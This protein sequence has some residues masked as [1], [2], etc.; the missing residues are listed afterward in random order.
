MPI[1][2]SIIA[3]VL[4]MVLY[5]IFIWK[6]DKYEPEPIRFIV[7]HF[8]WGAFGAVLFGV[9]GSM[10]LSLLTGF[11]G[12]GEVENAVRTILFAPISEETAK[13]V[14]L[15]W[16]INSRKFDNITDGIV[17]GTAIGLGFG[18]TENFMYFVSYGT[19]VSSWVNIVIIRSLFSAVMHG[20][21]TGTLGGFL[22]LAKYSTDFGRA[23]YPVAGI[24]CAVFIHFVW[25]ATVSFQITL[26]FGFLF[27]IALIVV[28]IS[29]IRF[30]VKNEKRIIEL[31]LE[32]E[33]LLGIIPVELVPI[34]ATHQR[35][36]KGWVDENIRKSFIRAAV[37]LAFSKMK[38][39]KT[40]GSKKLMYD[41]E[42]KNYRQLIQSLIQSNSQS[43]I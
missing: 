4:P 28:F 12:D 31:E 2:A 35:M 22:G 5:L 7:I 39:K 32:E 18:M 27:M 41:Y 20:I 17:Y 23:F 1:V 14:F 3:A 6:M 19:D 11:T 8:V 34:L 21:S 37:R 30:S 33:V 38:F 36:K 43:V 29:V 13:G 26:L 9:I 15:I 42:I 10:M 25:N 24:T 16:T 40:T